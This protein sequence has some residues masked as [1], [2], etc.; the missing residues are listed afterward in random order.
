S[1]LFLFNYRGIKF[2][3]TNLE[4]TVSP[5]TE[6][7]I[8]PIVKCLPHQLSILLFIF[9]VSFLS[10]GPSPPVFRP[11]YDFS[12]T[13]GVLHRHYLEKGPVFPTIDRFPSTSVHLQQH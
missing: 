11:V 7:A 9:C 8:P 4:Q 5:K 3:Y 13:I 2:E 1:D 6:T 10:R 12:P